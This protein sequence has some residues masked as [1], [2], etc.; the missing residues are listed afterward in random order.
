MAWF[1]IYNYKHRETIGNPPPAHAQLD[2]QHTDSI[3]AATPLAMTWCTRI[4]LRVGW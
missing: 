2:R 3:S 4:T 1:T